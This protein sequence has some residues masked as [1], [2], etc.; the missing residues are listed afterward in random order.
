MIWQEALS[1]SP[2]M[3]SADFTDD[4]ISIAWS[5][6]GNDMLIRTT[7]DIGIETHS[8]YWWR[9]NGDKLGELVAASE[10]RTGAAWSADGQWLVWYHQSTIYLVP[11]SET[12]QARTIELEGLVEGAT[13]LDD[14][15]HFLAWGREADRN[16]AHGWISTWRAEDLSITQTFATDLGIE[17]AVVMPDG[18]LLVHLRRGRLQVLQEGTDTKPVRLDHPRGWESKTPDWE[19]QTSEDGTLF[20]FPISPDAFAVVRADDPDNP[21]ICF[22]ERSQGRHTTPQLHPLSKRVVANYVQYGDG[23]ILLWDTTDCRQPAIELNAATAANG[24]SS[25]QWQGA[26][27]SPDGE[28]IVTW[29]LHNVLRIWQL[30][31]LD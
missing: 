27:L 17:D 20:L 31:D 10:F 26:A 19:I 29:G 24:E 7:S 5:P 1:A 8:L 28:S 14:S 3:L 13:W 30:D 22:D 25:L 2:K 16:T 4:I 18:R 21:V 12:G 11:M 15:Q 23:S 6:D 9:L